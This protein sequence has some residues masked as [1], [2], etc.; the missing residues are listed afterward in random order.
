MEASEKLPN[1]TLRT[2]PCRKSKAAKK[3]PATK[4]RQE[5]RP[6]SHFVILLQIPFSAL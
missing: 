2:V 1:A 5:N 6:L 4:M 3:S